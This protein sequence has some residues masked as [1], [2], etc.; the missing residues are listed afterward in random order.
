MSRHEGDRPWTTKAIANERII[1]E[2]LGTETIPHDIRVAL[3]GLS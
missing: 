1:I 2:N 3:P